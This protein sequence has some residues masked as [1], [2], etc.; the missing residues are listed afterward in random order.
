MA[1][2]IRSTYRFYLTHSLFGTVEAFPANNKIQWTYNKESGQVFYRKTLKTKLKFINDSKQ[3]IDDFTKLYQVERSA[4]KCEGVYLDV[5]KRCGELWSPVYRGVL[6]LIEGEWD[7]SNCVLLIEPRIADRY[8]CM[9]DNWDR[10]L[11]IYDGRQTG[12]RPTVTNLKSFDG[13]LIDTF[14]CRYVDRLVNGE[15]PPLIDTPCAFTLPEPRETWGIAQH[16]FQELVDPEDSPNRRVWICVLYAREIGLWSFDPGP[17]WIYLG[18]GP[19]GFDNYARPITEGLFDL[20][21]N[22]VVFR[23]GLR[24]TDVIRWLA[25]SYDPQEQWNLNLCELPVISNF[26]NISPDATNPDNYAYQKAAE[27]CQSLS[28]HSISDV[29]HPYASDPDTVWEISFKQLLDDLKTMFNVYWEID[30]DGNLRIEHISYFAR[31][32]MMNLTTEENRKY[33]DGAFK[34]TYNDYEVPKFELWKWQVQSRDEDFEGKPIEYNSLCSNNKEFKT[35]EFVA[36]NIHTNIFDIVIYPGKYSEANDQ[37]VLMSTNG[38]ETVKFAQG[39]LTGDQKIN[40]CLAWANLVD[41]FHQYNR[42]NWIGKL[43]NE[44]KNFFSVMNVRKQEKFSLP[45]C[46]EDTINFN[47]DILVKTQLGWGQIGSAI[48]DEP[49]NLLTLETLH[50]P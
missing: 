11:S 40:G 32:R 36:S 22:P 14:L 43:N 15:L 3:S 26:F 45:L 25:G 5:E 8:E 9:L 4:F 17:P 21:G 39:L 35:I 46:C 10:T 48:L 34:Y 13:N 41:Y 6:S 20:E 2:T 27:Y 42:P 37:F 16:Y 29:M 7:V 33:I 47:P 49:G 18:P 12:L 24:L 31:N 30:D 44:E 23:N 28:F 38:F 19:G 1:S 50:K